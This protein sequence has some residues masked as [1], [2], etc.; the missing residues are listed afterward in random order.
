M[1]LEKGADSAVAVDEI[2]MDV[3]RWMSRVT[4]DIIG[5]GMF[6]YLLVSEWVPNICSLSTAGFG[7]EFN[8]LSDST[9]ALAAA[10]TSLQ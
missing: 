3:S 2:T 4:L 5:A 6:E 7:Y 8:S 10:F 1:K 9:N